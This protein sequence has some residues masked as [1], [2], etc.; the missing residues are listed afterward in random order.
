[1]PNKPTDKTCDSQNPALAQGGGPGTEH[2]AGSFTHLPHGIFPTSQGSGYH[3]G[4][5]A[6]AQ[7]ES[8][9]TVS[10]RGTQAA[11]HSAFPLYL[12]PTPSAPPQSPEGKEPEAWSCQHPST[13]HSWTIPDDV[14]AVATEWS[15]AAGWEAL[16]PLDGAPGQWGHL[17][18][19]RGVGRGSSGQSL[20]A[21][22]GCALAR[23]KLLGEAVICH[24]WGPAGR[25]CRA[26]TIG[27]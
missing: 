26:P 18:T 6:K 5:E 8:D 15:P 20:L 3:T 22:G 11:L 16:G 1:M 17:E 13:G 23:S 21:D 7:R 27:H 24:P 2:C 10:Q 9:Q 19:R 12:P 4:M 14:V 25:L